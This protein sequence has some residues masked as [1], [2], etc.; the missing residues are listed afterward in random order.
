QRL[1]YSAG[2]VYALLVIAFK[3]LR[4]RLAE[5]EGTISEE[6]ANI[7]RRPNPN[8]PAGR[9]VRDTLIPVVSLLRANCPLRL[10]DLFGLDNVASQGLST[11]SLCGDLDSSDTFFKVV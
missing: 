1:T 7:M 4:V 10:L 9:A 6:I 2:T 11:Q 5:A 8:T 3:G